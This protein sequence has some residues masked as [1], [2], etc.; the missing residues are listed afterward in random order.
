MIFNLIF[1]VHLFFKSLLKTNQLRKYNL[2]LIKFLLNPLQMCFR[3]VQSIH[4]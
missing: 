3:H 2:K 4:N 1:F